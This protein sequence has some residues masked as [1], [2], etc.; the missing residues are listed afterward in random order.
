MTHHLEK[1]KRP[2]ERAAAITMHTMLYTARESVNSAQ[3][4]AFEASCGVIRG[5][6]SPTVKRGAAGG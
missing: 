5:L 4:G 6:E 2:L 1:S 3:Q